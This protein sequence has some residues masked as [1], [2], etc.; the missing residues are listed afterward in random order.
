MHDQLVHNS[1]VGWWWSNRGSVSST[2]WFQPV[3]WALCACSQH[4]FKFYH[5]VGIQICSKQLKHMAQVIASIG[6]PRWLSGQESA[7]QPR[8]LRFNPW[9]RKIP[10]RR[11]WQPTPV[12]LPGK[13]HGQRS[14]MGYSP[15]GCK[16]L[17][18]DLATKQQQSA[19]ILLFVPGSFFA[20]FFSWFRF[21]VWRSRFCWKPGKLSGRPLFSY[22]GSILPLCIRWGFSLWHNDYVPMLMQLK[23]KAVGWNWWHCC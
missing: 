6:L 18:H 8:R 14:L 7:C 10:W 17:R 22:F 13:S 16:R 15:W 9:V 3:F 11:K 1:L 2:F 12:L 23:S 20:D 19:P 4:A 21:R 5:M